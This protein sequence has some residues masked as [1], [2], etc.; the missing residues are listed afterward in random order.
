CNYCGE[1]F[2]GDHRLPENH[3]CPKIGGPLQ[4]GY[5]RRYQPTKAPPR[6]REALPSLRSG[7]RSLR[8]RY[9]GLFSKVESRHMLIATGVMTLAGVFLA[10]YTSAQFDIFG[11]QSWLLLSLIP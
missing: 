7:P 11:A 10:F 9:S 4:P 2:C 8:L 1:M 3:A 6:S 5:A